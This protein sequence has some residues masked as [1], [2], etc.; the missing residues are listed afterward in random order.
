M[1]WRHIVNDRQVSCSVKRQESDCEKRGICSIDQEGDI[2][3][4][5]RR[6]RTDQEGRK[7]SY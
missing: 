6:F 4:K 7:S 1:Q 2:I 3:E 5:K